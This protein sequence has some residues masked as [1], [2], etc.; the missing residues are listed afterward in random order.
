[1]TKSCQKLLR[2]LIPWGSLL[3]TMVNERRKRDFEV[4]VHTKWK[5]N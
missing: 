4:N 3:Q 2:S 1:M 5:M